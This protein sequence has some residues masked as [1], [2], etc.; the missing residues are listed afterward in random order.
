MKKCLLQWKIKKTTK[1]ATNGLVSKR[2]RKL[3]FFQGSEIVKKLTKKLN[4][5]KIVKKLTI[6][7]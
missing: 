6:K 1:S 5:R 7:K 2:E 3:S 4:G